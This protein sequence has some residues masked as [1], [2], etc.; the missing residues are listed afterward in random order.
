MFLSLAQILSNNPVFLAPMAGVTD[1]PFRAL[2]SRYGAGLVFSEMVASRPAVE[3]FRRA[4]D[5]NTLKVSEHPL[6]VQLAGCEPE[7]IAEAAKIHEQRGAFIIDLNFGCPVKK[8]VNNFSGAALMRDELLAARIMESVVKAVSI[9]VTIKM[10]LGWDDQNLNA[11]R[12]A[13]I[14]ESTGL[15]MITVH[16]RTRCQL[17][18]GNA[19]WHAVRRVKE[20]VS[21]PVLV[22]GDITDGLRA[23]D[24]IA[25]SGADGVMVGRGAFGK[26]WALRDIAH[27]LKT[28]GVLPAPS[29]RE[30][31]A[32]L[33]EHYQLLLSHYGARAGNAIARKHI[34][35]YC[36][37]LPGSEALRSAVNALEDPAPV[38]QT[39]SDYFD[40][41]EQAAA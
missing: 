30:I 4:P 16:G 22:N 27:F 25:Q 6:A 31:G 33:R 19:D 21:I 28:G 32:T 8:V 24:A 37:D 17:Y 2:V 3:E 18:S 1:A 26:P 9:P 39:L 40:S 20:A 13:K 10:R 41:L 15:S 35:W 14:A 5:S 7:I 11:P 29:M 23:K 36:A 34:G 12:L 38:L